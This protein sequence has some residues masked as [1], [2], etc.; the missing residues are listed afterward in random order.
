MAYAQGSSDV[1]GEPSIVERLAALEVEQRRLADSQLQLQ[2]EFD[3]GPGDELSDELDDALNL[4]VLNGH[5][6]VQ[7]ELSGRIHLDVWG[8][9]SSSPGVNGFATGDEDTTPQ[10]RIGFRR[11]RLQASGDLA[12]DMLYKLEIE[13][14]GGSDVEFRDAYLGWVDLPVLQTLLIGN[15]KR[16]YGLDHLNSSRYNVFIERP[17]VIEAFNQDARRLGVQSYGVSDDEVFNWRYGVFNQRLVQDEG[18]YISDHWQGQIAGRLASVVWWARDGRD[19]CHAAVSGTWADTD[20]GA[21]TNNYAGS[22]INEANF[23]TRPEARTTLRWLDTGV[24]AD[25]TDYTLVGLEQ[26][27]NVGPLQLVSEQ[28]SVEVR[29][30]GGDTV[31]F[32]G[33]YGYVSYFLTG[34][35]I[36]WDRELGLIER[37]VPNENFYLVDTRCG[38][39]KGLGA[40]Q[41]ALRWSYLDLA[42]G[43][44]RGGD[45]QALTAALNWH[46]TPYAKL[47]FNYING[48]INDNGANAPP[49]APAFG[50]YEILGMRFAVDF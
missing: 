24:I 29:R 2:E 14:A 36:P 37:V 23:R 4:R 40:W 6:G 17:F 3:E 46:W 43:D 12:Q 28:Q 10:D 18:A 50:D 34:E 22:G 32:H 26:V 47:Q 20:Q 49:G 39:K 8:Y 5:T 15:Q 13:F 44:I 45:G 42:D 21:A 41:V 48:Q 33:A 11:M 27:L 9:P 7:S 25:A 16:P 31:H 19:F 38:V 1:A 30:L 35:H